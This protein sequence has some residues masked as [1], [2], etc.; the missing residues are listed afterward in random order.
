MIWG[1]ID[2]MAK[3]ARIIPYV[4][5]VLG[6]L[7]AMSGQYV[8]SLV[9][10]HVDTLRQRAEVQMKHTS[11]SLT[12]DVT[13]VDSSNVKIVVAAQNY[14]PVRANW[15]FVTK[16]NQVVSGIMTE[17]IELHPTAA[18]SK[19]NHTQ[20]LQLDRVKDGFIELRLDYV[21]VYSAEVGNPS[22]LTGRIV[23][24]Y[25]LANGSLRPVP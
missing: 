7:V 4:F 13:L 18:S 22:N 23:R 10:D 24:A 11:P 17:K 15:L 6:F 12:A 8:Q 9:T 16:D 20:S 25:Q 19:W 5:I 2:G 1:D 21:S 14:I 3:L